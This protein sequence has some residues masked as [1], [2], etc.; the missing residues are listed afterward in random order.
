M[1][2]IQFSVDLSPSSG[3]IDRLADGLSEHAL[4]IVDRDGFEP[5][6]IFARDSDK[7]LIGGAYG[8]LNWEWL[9]LSLLWVDS[10]QRKS[11]MGEQLL[12]RI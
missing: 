8:K 9:H 1:S 4:S 12:N 11:G 10:S 6:A 7:A 2:D 3:D 5:I